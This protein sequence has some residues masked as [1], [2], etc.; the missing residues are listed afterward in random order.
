MLQPV[1]TFNSIDQAGTDIASLLSAANYYTFDVICDD[2]SATFTCQDSSTGLLISRQTITVPITGQR[3]FSS[4]QSPVIARLYNTGS[5]PATAPQMFLTDFIA[6]QLDMLTNKPYSD[7]MSSI[8][9]SS[10]ESPFTGAQL[11]TWSN[12]AEPASATLSNTAAGYTTL[13]GKFQFAAVAGA[14]TDY[15]LFGFQIPAPANLMITGI[16]IDTWN[17]VVAVATTPTL[18]VWALGFGST[19]VSLA[20]ASIVRVPIGAQSFPV[21]EAAGAVAQRITKQF[22]TPISIGSARF[23]QVIL[24]MPVGTATATEV[25]AGLVNIEGYFE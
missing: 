6:L 5:A 17:T 12:S 7:V 1:L 21:G 24:R 2:D 22:R 19:A 15:A 3:L 25:F 10:W 18:L 13:G 14:V 9:R 4:S 16:D 11:A 20:S 23:V 8:A